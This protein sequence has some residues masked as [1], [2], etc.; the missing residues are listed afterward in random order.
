MSL[1]R[2]RDMRLLHISL[3]MAINFFS[4]LLAFA[5]VTTPLDAS[6]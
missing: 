6:G 1:I 5:I 3:E 4:S 2:H